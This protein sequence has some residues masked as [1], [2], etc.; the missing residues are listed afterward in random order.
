VDLTKP[1]V[2]IT[3]HPA[4]PTNSTSASFT[5]TANDPTS[6]GVS[7]GIDK[8]KCKIDA[9]AYADCTT[10]GSQSY[11]GLALGSHTFKV[12]A[13]DKA[14]NVSDEQVYTWA[15]HATTSL[16]YQQDTLVISGNNL[17][18]QAQIT[19]SAAVC[20]GSVSIAFSLASSPLTPLPSPPYSLVMATTSGSGVASKSVATTG[21]LEGVY[22]IT[23]SYAGS[24]SCD[25][26]TYTAELTVA[27]PGDSANGGGWFT[28]PNSGRV[29]FGF[30]VQKVPNTSPQQ[31]K[32][33]FVFINNGKW[34]MLNG[35]MGDWHLAA[36]GVGFSAQFQDNGSGSKSTADTI[37][38]LNILY[39]PVGPQPSTLPTTT[40][41]NL[42]NLKG[43][44][45]KVS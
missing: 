6:G 45:I 10:T 24:S 1:T 38:V 4:N 37:G 25:A 32:G 5:F 29:N 9:L 2:T 14:G 21:W 22:D 31:Y 34:R 28:Q 41:N 44:D 8:V 18:V 23:A 19:S 35:G 7:S 40:A 39:T 30:T 13:I 27:N 11:S 3:G 12:E 16:L 36:T 26:A 43:G 33:Q 20:Q 42:N 15:I 17:T